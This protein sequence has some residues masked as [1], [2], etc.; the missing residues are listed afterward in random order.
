MSEEKQ[1]QMFNTEEEEREFGRFLLSAGVCTVSFDFDGEGGDTTIHGVGFYDKDGK[2]VPE[3][4]WKVY[5]PLPD[6]NYL[7]WSVHAFLVDRFYDAA[8]ATGIDWRYDDGGCGSCNIIIHPDGL[9]GI[10]LQIGQR[11]IQV[12]YKTFSIGRVEAS[13]VR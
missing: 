4:G 9:L 1:I 6:A 8:D 2:G 11:I 5:K 10:E 7:R 3:I 12:D 13:H